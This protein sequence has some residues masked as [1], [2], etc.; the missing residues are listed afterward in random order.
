MNGEIESQTVALVAATLHADQRSI[1]RDTRL[2]ADLG[3][4]SLDFVGLVLALEDEFKVDIH[5]E[6]AAELL[7]VGQIIDYVTLAR[8][9]KDSE[10][11][12][13]AAGGQ[14]VGLR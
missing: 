5:D 10:M 11:K 3:A 9:V 8:T 12:R 6:D 14:L 2:A 13:R 1:S 4:D 7:T